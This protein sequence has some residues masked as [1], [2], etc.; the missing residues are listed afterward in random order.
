MKKI[1]ASLLLLVPV[2]SFAACNLNLPVLNIGIYNPLNSNYTQSSSNIGVVCDAPQNISLK[3]TEG[4]S[5]NMNA[6]TMLGPRNNKLSYNLFL[7]SGRGTVFGNGVNS[8]Y[9]S[10]IN[11]NIPIF[12]SIVPKQLVPAGFYSDNLIV[13]LSF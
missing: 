8:G 9:Y 7:D 10:G 12:M 11:N 1:L 6:R 2:W 5:A 3:I 13:E 4:F